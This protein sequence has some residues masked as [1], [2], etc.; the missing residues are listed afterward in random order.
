MMESNGVVS[1]TFT[2]EVLEDL[3]WKCSFDA[4][5]RA[6]CSLTD[7]KGR[8]SQLSHVEAILPLPVMFDKVTFEIL[9]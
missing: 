2:V 9:V 8:P 4:K 3:T 1:K 5:I 7:T 6:K